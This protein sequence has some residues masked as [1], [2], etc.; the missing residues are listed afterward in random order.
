VLSWCRTTPQFIPELQDA[1]RPRLNDEHPRVRAEVVATLSRLGQWT[2][3]DVLGVLKLL[4]DSDPDVRMRTAAW[5]PSGVETRSV[6][7][8]LCR[9][10][11]DSDPH[12]RR[13]AAA[14]LGSFG[15][16]AEDA[17]EPLRAAREDQ[18]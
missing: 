9:A 8:A 18:D 16:E 1:I 11:T 5:L 6:V 12:V 10:T 4:D 7:R 17:L 13:A 2:S 15:V 3:G 14:R